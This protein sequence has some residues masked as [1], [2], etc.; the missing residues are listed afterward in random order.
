MLGEPVSHSRPCAKPERAS[1]GFKEAIM[2]INEITYAINGAVFEVNKILGEGYLEKVYEN[3]L[4]LELQK[5]GLN[6]QN[7]VPVKVLY[8]GEVV[9]DYYADIIVEESVI[10]ELKVVE[11]LDR[12]HAAQLLNYLRG[13]GYSIGLLIN[14]RSPKAQIK[15][16]V[17]KFEKD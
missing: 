11:S 17:N 1:N 15:R 2:D 12:L 3:A 8:K 6:V 10:L 4:L 16:V 14:F 7:Q 13:T 9:G 5:R